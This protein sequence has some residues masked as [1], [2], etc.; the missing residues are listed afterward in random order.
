MR[1]YLFNAVVLNS[2]CFS[3]ALYTL[4]FAILWSILAVPRPVQ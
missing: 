3:V 1:D 4:L 2:G